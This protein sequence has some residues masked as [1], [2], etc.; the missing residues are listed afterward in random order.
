MFLNKQ[1][2]DFTSKNSKVLDLLVKGT[3]ERSSRV[4]PSPP[5]SI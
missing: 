2:R 5:S 4:M 3:E 1:W